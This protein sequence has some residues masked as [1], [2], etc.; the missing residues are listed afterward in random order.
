VEQ[1]VVGILGG[2]DL[3]VTEETTN[4]SSENPEH[5]ENEQGSTDVVHDGL[6]VTRVLG[7]LNKSSGTTNERVTGSSSDNTVGLA[8]LATGG[9]VTGVGHVLVDGE[10]LTSDGG[11]ITS[12]ERNTLVNLTLIIVIITVLLL[13]SVV[14][15]VGEVL[16]VGLE[17]LGLGVVTDQTDIGR[18]NGTLL[19]DNNITSNELTGEDLLLLTVADNDS[20]H[21]NITLERSHDIGSLL[22]LVPTD[23]SVE[24]KNTTDNT[25]ID[26]VTETGSEEDSEF[27]N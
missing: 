6:E 3:E 9:V 24:Q 18:D 1:V 19:D 17:H 15:G 22:L 23:E 16:L 27:H 14:G 8:T 5:D 26:P 20:T 10:R 21:S 2:S 12:N 25:E 4:P 11:L 13:E 7:T